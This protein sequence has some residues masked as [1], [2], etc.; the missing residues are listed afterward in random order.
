[1]FIP[2]TSK[3]GFP[4]EECIDFLSAEISHDS[5]P[6]NALG[7]LGNV[8]IQDGCNYW[9]LLSTDEQQFGKFCSI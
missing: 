5:P 8:S 2:L 6:K 3:I 4:S 9:G 1:M 7:L